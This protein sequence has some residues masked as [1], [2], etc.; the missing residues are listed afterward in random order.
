MTMKNHEF[1]RSMVE[2]L[3]TLAIIGVLSVVAIAGYSYGMDKYRAN[4]TIHEVRL[5]A[6]DVLA[7]LAKTGTANLNEWINEPTIYPITL[8][9]EGY[10]IQV[11]KIPERV[12]EIIAEGRDATLNA[13]KINTKLIEKYAD[14]CNDDNSLVFYYSDDWTTENREK[15]GNIICE[16][17]QVCDKS[18]MECVS[19]TQI[20]KTLDDFR[21]CT[22]NGY[23]SYCDIITDGC[24]ELATC[25]ED[26]ECNV[27]IDGECQALDSSL[28]LDHGLGGFRCTKNGKD[29]YCING[30]CIPPCTVDSDCT[31]AS[32]PYCSDGTCYACTENAHC[33]NTASDYCLNN[34]CATC[35]ADKPYWNNAIKQCVECLENT[36]C[37]TTISDYCLNNSC[38][39]CPAEKP[40]WDANNQVC[41][42]LENAHCTDEALPYCSDG[43]CVACTENAHCGTTISDYCLNNSCGK[44][45]TNQPY[46]DNDNQTCSCP[47]QKPYLTRW[48]CS[49]CLTNDHCGGT[50]YCSYRNACVACPTA[51]PYWNEASSSCVTCSDDSHCTDASLPYCSNGTCAEC[52][53]N[54]HCGSKQYCGTIE[55]F[56][57]LLGKCKELKF[58]K[59]TFNDETYYVSDD[60]MNFWD[61]QAACRTFDNANVISMHELVVNEDGTKWDEDYTSY[62]YKSTPL[63]DF[64]CDK[65]SS[66]Y[67]WS[68]EEQDADFFNLVYKN[69]SITYDGRDIDSYYYVVCH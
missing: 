68:R 62:E 10:G 65:R 11:D 39:T 15:C 57:P 59:Y 34:A 27:R 23:K 21:I 18:K 41:T 37:G 30:V 67:F 2:M 1:G 28:Y 48:G 43:T 17:C 3:G 66:G 54:E 16:E 5:R 52:S 61:G 12:C 22:S 47:P 53:S 55:T 56:K 50:G 38:A 33:G 36:H 26:P 13:L 8:E 4:Q 24:A 6:V 31:D 32:L 14:E 49:E 69:G 7:Q 64:L 63:A 45:S 9:A 20:A 42:C 46:W 51:T 29:G 40:Y 58:T 60:P 44:C 35:P 19:P 25:E